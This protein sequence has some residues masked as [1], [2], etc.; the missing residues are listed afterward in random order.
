MKK[1]VV[2]SRMRAAFPAWFLSCFAIL[3]II[4]GSGVRVSAQALQGI[5]GTV[6]D[7]SGGVVPNA[8]VTATNDATA[9]AKTATTNSAGT[10]QFTDL[11]PGSYTVRMESP[12]FQSSVHSG[13]TVD[14][15]K[16]STV[17]GVLQPGRTEQ[18]VNVTETAV[19][20]DTTQPALGTTIENK[21]V[22]ELPNEV[23]GGRGRQIDQFVFLAPGVT[24]DTFS[25]RVNGGVEFQCA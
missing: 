3:L 16:V 19:A 5:T 23:S 17:D 6:T 11:I 2:C 8:T 12:G 9:V 20:L 14:V 22:Q 4:G 10:Y 21:V 15:G 18:T 25:H 7:A 13:V 24:G 1:I